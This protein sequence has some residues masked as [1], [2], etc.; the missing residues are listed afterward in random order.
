MKA[1][2]RLLTKFK[3]LTK[4]RIVAYKDCS[5]VKLVSV[6]DETKLLGCGSGM[7]DARGNYGPIKLIAPT[8]LPHCS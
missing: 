3:N 7:M 1:L 8:S 6:L 2:E 5:S 4:G